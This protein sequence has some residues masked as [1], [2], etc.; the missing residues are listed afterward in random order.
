MILCY[1][2]E[3]REDSSLV[4]TATP[5]GCSGRYCPD[6]V[7]CEK[8]C[9]CAKKILVPVTVKW[10]DSGRWKRLLE[11]IMQRVNHIYDRPSAAKKPTAS[12]A[13]MPVILD[14]RRPEALGR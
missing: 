13:D 6:C 12:E 14:P 3:K 1:C 11:P 5:C 4:G 10:D 8:H 7:L 2:C 9:R